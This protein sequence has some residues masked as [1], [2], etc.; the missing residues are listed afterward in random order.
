[1]NSFT[2]YLRNVRAEMEHV[3]WPSQKQAITHVAL[4][5]GISI[6]TALLISGLDYAFTQGVGV[7][8]NR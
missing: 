1:M 6:F 3:V 2:S 7:L 8:V 5:M 4:I